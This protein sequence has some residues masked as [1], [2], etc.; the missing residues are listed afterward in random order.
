MNLEL[1]DIQGQLQDSLS[2]LLAK[3]Y[4]FEARQAYA[5][6]PRGH[7]GDVWAQLADLGVLGAAIGEEW[8]GFGGDAVDQMLVAQALGKV[9]ALEPYHSSIIMA[10]TAL[11]AMGS[12]AQKQAWLPR[13][14][15][16]EAQLGWAHQAPAGAQ[17]ATQARRTS[18]VW[19]LHGTK[20]LVLNA[21]NCER[22]VVSALDETGAMALYLADTKSA[23]VRIDSYRLLD[24]TLAADVHF[25]GVAG[26]RLDGVDGA[27]AASALQRVLDTGIT[28]ACADMLGAMEG[29][30]A[31]TFDYLKTRHQFGRAIGTNQALQ[32]RAVE[33]LIGIEQSRSLVMSLALT[34]AGRND[35]SIGGGQFHAAKVLVGRNARVVAQESIQMHGGIGMTEECAVGHYLRRVLVLDQLHGDTHAHLA[36]LENFPH[37]TEDR[38]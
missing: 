11:Q 31:L 19:R 4:S 5:R 16:G 24:D 14:A 26:E 38:K 22:L 2:R 15:Q 27:N 33:M 1:N 37:P 35:F 34:L 23:G 3:Q 20:V 36:V 9:L 7:S 6:D 12:Q 28:A 25:E 18:G 21:P 30:S 8:G 29:A 10:A 32:H 17:H 13:I